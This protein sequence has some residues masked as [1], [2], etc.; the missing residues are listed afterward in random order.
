MGRGTRTCF[1]GWSSNQAAARGWLTGLGPGYERADFHKAAETAA[2]LMRDASTPPEIYFI[3]DFQR[4]NWSDT[5]FAGL[6]PSARVFFVTVGDKDKPRENRAITQVEVTSGAILAGGEVSLQIQ[7]ANYTATPLDEP[8]E[9]VVDGRES[10][11]S[12][13]TAAPWS[14][15]RLNVT[16]HA[17]SPGWHQVAVRFKKADSLPF[18]DA[19]YLP[20]QVTEK[21]EVAIVTQDI[22]AAS[23]GA[24]TMRFLEAAINPYADARGSM[25]PRRVDATKLQP[26]DLA[27]TT[28]VVITR[29]GKLSDV[30][31]RSLADYLKSG[32]GALYFLDGENDQQNLD[33]L[34]EFTAQA[35]SVPLK[36]SARTIV[37]NGSPDSASQ[38]ARGQFDSRYLRLF[39]GAAREQL[40][41]LSF[42]E[43]WNATPVERA[44]VI[45]G[46]ADGTPA[47]AVGHPGLGTLLLCNFSVAE[48]ASNIARQRLFPAWIQE[49]VAQLSG[50]RAAALRYE[51]GD[52]MQGD[53]WERDARRLEFTGPA[54]QTVTAARA[55]DGE[56]V[57]LLVPANEPG[58]YTLGD[59]RKRPVALLAANVSPAESDLRILP[60]DVAPQQAKADAIQGA[61]GLGAG[62]DY[63][64]LSHGRPVYHWFIFAALMALA[65][66]TL[67]QIKVRRT[68]A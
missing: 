36:L 58:F 11:E 28:K 15:Q 1:T 22:T 6:P 20:L 48:I 51:P 16:I 23:K 55:P 2:A 49:L 29:A 10:Y 37:D 62:A 43:H 38:I 27:A 64:E 34:R 66:E 57:H 25:M 56:R 26:A 31:V 24:L 33:A 14:V 54:G 30:Q 21:E 50:E 18:D 45:L 63:H 39:R 32:G 4:T 53:A 19:F 13:V 61:F 40:A 41:Q 60:P 12:R 7:A 68:P 17:P 46:Y 42:Y 3:S 9:T 5:S 59:Q 47:M 8:V 67:L 44:S 35:E 65:I 52:S